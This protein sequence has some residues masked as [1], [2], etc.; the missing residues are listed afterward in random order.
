MEKEGYEPG[1]LYPDS[2]KEEEEEENEYTSRKNSSD[3]SETEFPTVNM[4]PTANMRIPLRKL[5][6]SKERPYTLDAKIF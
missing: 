5:F 6:G 1:V 4:I 3:S 2:E